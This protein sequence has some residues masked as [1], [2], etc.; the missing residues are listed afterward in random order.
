MG[1]IMKNNGKFYDCSVAFT[2]FYQNSKNSLVHF[3][4]YM[5]TYTYVW[6]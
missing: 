1:N 3:Y 6:T 4:T 5:H 2:N